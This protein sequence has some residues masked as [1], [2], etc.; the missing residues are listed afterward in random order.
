MAESFLLVQWDALT[1]RP[2]SA[3]RQTHLARALRDTARRRPEARRERHSR[4]PERPKISDVRGSEILYATKTVTSFMKFP[5]KTAMPKLKREVRYL[6]GFPQAEWATPGK[7][8]R[9]TWICTVTA[10]GQATK[11]GN[12]RALELQRSLE[13]IRST[14]RR[15][16]NHWSRCL[17]RRRSPTL[18]IAGGL[19]TCH[20]LTEAGYEVIPRVWSKQ[21]TGRVRHS[22]IRHEARVE[23][24]ACGR[25]VDDESRG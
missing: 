22:E 4:L 11:S 1:G 7:V 5:T 19:Q 2:T 25:I 21:G 16:R 14:L 15:R 18:A 13:V 23:E 9:S 6:L 10:T 20:L 3:R 12:A 24:E 8:C 17:P